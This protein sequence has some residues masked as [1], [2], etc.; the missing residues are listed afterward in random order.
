MNNIEFTFSAEDLQLALKFVTWQ[1]R[2]KVCHKVYAIANRNFLD[3][4]LL[5][6]WYGGNNP[7]M[8]E[9]LGRCYFTCPDEE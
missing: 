2:Q 7:V 3:I 6:N 4:H 1:K 9:S 5:K 8:V